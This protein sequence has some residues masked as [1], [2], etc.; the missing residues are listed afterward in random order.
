MRLRERLEI[1]AL[2]ARRYGAQAGQP[3][4][5]QSLADQHGENAVL[6]WLRVGVPTPRLDVPILAV[7]LAAGVTEQRYRWLVSGGVALGP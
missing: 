1:R 6:D 4:Q 5:L 2:A 3:Y 7:L